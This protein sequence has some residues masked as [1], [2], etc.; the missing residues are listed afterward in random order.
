MTHPRFMTALTAGA[1]ALVL[2]L[3]APARAGS[4]TARIIAGAAAL[5]IIGVAIAEALDDDRNAHVARHGYGP[6]YYP[7]PTYRV[8]RHDPYAYR[9]M[10]HERRYHRHGEYCHHRGYR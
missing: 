2:A 4:D 10:R 6:A 3:P 9:A 5:T 8:R 7:R 1:L